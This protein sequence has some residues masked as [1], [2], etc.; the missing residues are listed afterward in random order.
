MSFL[1]R[2]EVTAKTVSALETE[3]KNYCENI[4]AFPISLFQILKL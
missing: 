4:S 3:A 1:T 2:I